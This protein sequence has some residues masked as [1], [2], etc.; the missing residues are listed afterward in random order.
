MTEP[1]WS[2]YDN[3]ALSDVLEAASERTV[4]KLPRA[5]LARVREVGGWNAAHKYGTLSV[6]PFPLSEGDTGPS[7]TTAYRFNKNGFNVGDVV[8]VVYTDGDFRAGLE[9]DRAM[10]S[11]NNQTASFD[12][13]VAIK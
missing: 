8:L 4:S 6:E 11:D 12:W 9:Q 5:T 3:K 7:R 10:L 13:A 2:K 1:V